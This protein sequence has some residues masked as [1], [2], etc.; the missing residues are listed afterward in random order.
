[1]ARRPGARAASSPTR[2]VRGKLV[3]AA[4]FLAFSLSSSMAGAQTRK[5]GYMKV[6]GYKSLTWGMSRSQVKAALGLP[7]TYSKD[8]DVT[9][10]KGPSAYACKFRGMKLYAWETRP[11]N[12][13]AAEAEFDREY[14]PFLTA[15]IGPGRVLKVWDDGETQIQFES[16][17][18]PPI[19]SVRVRFK[20]LVGP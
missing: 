19:D 15:A 20:R 17:H 4:A 18:R 9:Y 10:G 5:P 8:D 13:D 14:G 12:G 2:L 1:M 16:N 3:F 7:V 6:T 11:E